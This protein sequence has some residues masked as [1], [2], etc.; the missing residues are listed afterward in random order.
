MLH[1]VVGAR[2]VQLVEAKQRDR[3]RVQCPVVVAISQPPTLDGS[4]KQRERERERV[5]GRGCG[6]GGW[7]VCVCV[8]MMCEERER[9]RERACERAL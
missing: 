1:E 6:G 9:E 5:G 7:C 3:K 8:C 2:F 4:E